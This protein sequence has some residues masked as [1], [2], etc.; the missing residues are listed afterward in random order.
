MMTN[1]LEIQDVQT[2]QK[3]NA[4][5]KSSSITIQ[6]ARRNVTQVDDVSINE[7]IIEKTLKEAIDMFIQNLDKIS[8]MDIKDEKVR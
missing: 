5:N 2:F 7:Y 1:E 3:E 6:Q 8:K 4:L